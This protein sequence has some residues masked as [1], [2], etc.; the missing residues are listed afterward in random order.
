MGYVRGFDDEIL[1][2]LKSDDEDLHYQA[3]RAASNWG[4][5]G[6]WPHVRALVSQ[7]HPDK[8]LLLAAIEAVGAI[9]PE[10]ADAVLGHLLDSDDEDVVDAVEE[11]LM[12]AEGEMGLGDD[13]DLDE[14]EWDEND[15]GHLN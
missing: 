10:E 9:R 6:A 3:V 8:V 15:D 2:A 5:D 14:D 11:A 13:D 1:E 12:L 7:P 4:L